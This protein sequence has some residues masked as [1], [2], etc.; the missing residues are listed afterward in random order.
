MVFMEAM[1]CGLPIITYD[2][3]AIA[4][5]VGDVGLVLKENDILGLGKT[6]DS[7]IHDEF[8]RQLFSM[9]ARKRAEKYFDSKKTAKEL[10]QL[11]RN[12]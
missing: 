11:Y 1:A 5:V 2:T 8:K 9:K 3:G 10:E 4:E 6:L 7:L 12:M